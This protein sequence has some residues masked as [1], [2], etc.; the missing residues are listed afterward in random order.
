MQWSNA[1]Q[2][3]LLECQDDL[4][5]DQSVLSQKINAE[6]EKADPSSILSF[7]KKMICLAE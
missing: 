7:Y 5:S 3:W 2:G 6:S 4:A 1:P